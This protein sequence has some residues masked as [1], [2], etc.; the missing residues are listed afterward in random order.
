MAKK[1]SERPMYIRRL[2]GFP[3]IP[4]EASEPSRF[5]RLDAAWRAL[6]PDKRIAGVVAIH[7]GR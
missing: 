4:G 3:V 1:R 7:Q 5:P 6:C 2:V